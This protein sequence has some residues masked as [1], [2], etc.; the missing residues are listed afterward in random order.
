MRSRSSSSSRRCVRII[1]GPSVAI[2]K[3]TSCSRNAW[4]VSR[5]A[6]SSGRAFV[7]RFEVGQ[8]SST[9][10]ASRSSRISSGS[11]AARIPCPIRSGRRCS[12]T[13]PI[14][15]APVAPSSPTWIVTP[16]PAS[17]AASHHRLEAAV[18]VAPPRRARPGHVD[19]DDAARGPADRLLDDDLVL[20]LRERAVHHQDQ[21]AAH[22]GVL[23]RGP[24]EAADGR[25]DDVVEVAL[26]AAVALHRVEA[27]LERR[28]VLRA[29]GAADRA[30]D[31]A[32]DGERGGL[33]QL[34]P[35]V[36]AVERVE[37][38][39]AAGVRDGDERVELPVVLHRQ[40]DALLV[41]ERPE[42][43]GGDGAAEVGVQ[44]G[45][46]LRQ[47]RSAG[48]TSSRARRSRGARAGSAGRSCAAGI[49]AVE[50]VGA[51][52]LDAL[53]GL[54]AVLHRDDVVVGAVADRDRVPVEA[55]DVQL[56]A[57]RRRA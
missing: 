28:D 23:H 30:V 19:A 11:P 14:S 17:R 37:V 27:E 10:P 45:E 38:L 42:D 40:R 24:V 31:G 44:L 22:L 34:G 33:D 9:T 1:S 50:H 48:C 21:A 35:V 51:G 56:E 29:V 36:D 2:V 4:K 16:R 18:V 3:A 5:T 20:T 12:T 39:D 54:T 55:G 6:A 53:P 26:A 46:P 52:L 32:F 8:I 25:E 47:R 49:L 57:L 13:S 15:S 41:R 43:V 7:S